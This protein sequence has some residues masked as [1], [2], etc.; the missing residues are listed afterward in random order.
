MR[1]EL[2]DLIQCPCCGGDSFSLSVEKTSEAEILSGTVHCYSC[3]LG[4][5]IRDGIL[6]LLW[7]PSEVVQKEITAVSILDAKGKEAIANQSFEIT[8]EHHR[9]LPHGN[10]SRVFSDVLYFK[11]IATMAPDVERMVSYMRLRAGET[12]L[13]VGADTCW[14]SA[15]LTRADARVVAVDILMEHLKGGGSHLTDSLYFDRVLCDIKKLSFKP[16][17]VDAVACISTLHHSENLLLS[18]QQIYR[19]I[20]GGG[21]LM[22]MDDS[23]TEVH[24]PDTAEEEKSLGINENIYRLRD[25]LHAAHSAGFTCRP[26]L[27]FSAVADF[28]LHRVN[29][30]DRS[31]LK[32]LVYRVGLK[33][34]A[35]FSTPLLS[36]AIFPLFA[37]LLRRRANNNFPRSAEIIP[38]FR[39]GF[40]AHKPRLR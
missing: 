1:K 7:K 11:R 32:L 17:S 2:L 36:R 27:L 21:C 14:A 4:L 30:R 40:I 19:I 39:F 29:A 26:Y 13:D 16:N 3:G 6:D 28:C 10:G 38:L 31:R 9:S 8:A 22:A 20:K 34:C 25:Y 12:V 24:P 37:L 35:L 23:F 33:A 15:F 18:F 5:Q